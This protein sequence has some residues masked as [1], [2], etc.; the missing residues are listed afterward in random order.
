MATNAPPAPAP[1]HDPRLKQ[2]HWRD[3][4]HLQW[5]E[6]AWEL[7][8]PIPWLILSLFFYAHNLWYIGSPCSFFFFL[9]G[10]RLSHNAQHN[11]LGIPRRAHDLALFTIGALML[12]SGHAVQVT[13][14]HHHRHCL[15]E[16]DIEAWPAKLP[17]WRVILL[18][19]LF[20]YTL[21]RS[22][23]KLATPAKRRWIAAELATVAL[24][25]TAALAIPQL[26]FLRWHL[27][28]ML[29]G[30]WLV[31]FFAVWTVHRGCDP[32][33][34]HDPRIA[35]TQRGLLKNLMTYS[36]LYHIE[37]HLFPA[38]PTCHLPQLAQR[39][40]AAAPDLKELQVY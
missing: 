39:L 7:T 10:L 25:F 8:L 12:S 15:E 6:K 3:L 4:V 30:E 32:H 34:H 33:D 31:G 5:W 23:W 28:A 29:A 18:G 27:A 35:R 40:D 22:A 24:L 37:H 26:L 20:P 1:R 9:T 38:I 2:V 16:E 14:L 21:H 19:P 13:H 11:C 17:G 36:M